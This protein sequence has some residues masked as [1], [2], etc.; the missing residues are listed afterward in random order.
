MKNERCEG[1]AYIRLIKAPQYNYYFMLGEKIKHPTIKRDTPAEIEGYLSCIRCKVDQLCR[2]IDFDE[3]IAF[4]RVSDC[5]D[6]AVK[7]F[8]RKDKV[9]DC[10]IDL[11]APDWFGLEFEE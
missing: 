9:P 7:K 5:I 6:E 8:C 1:G 2:G 3:D 11:G 4:D 10:E